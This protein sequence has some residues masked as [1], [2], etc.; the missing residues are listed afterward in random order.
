MERAACGGKCRPDRID[1]Q[2]AMARSGIVQQRKLRSVAF[3]TWQGLRASA[4]AA[5]I[6]NGRQR[7]MSSH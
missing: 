3:E 1:R 2:H 5:P 7:S 4:V 6:T